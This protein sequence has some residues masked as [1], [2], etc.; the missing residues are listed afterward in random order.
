MA[1]FSLDNSIGYMLA[2]SGYDKIR[3]LCTV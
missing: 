1:L 3:T 2:V